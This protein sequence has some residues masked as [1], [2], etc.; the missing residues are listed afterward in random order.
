MTAGAAQTAAGG[1]NCPSGPIGL[2]EPCSDAH[3]TKAGPIGNIIFGSLL[4]G[5][6]EDTGTA[7]AVDGAGNVYGTTPAGGDM[8]C[9][10]NAKGCG[11]AFELSPAAN[12]VWNEIVLHTFKGAADGGEPRSGLTLDASGNLYGTTVFGGNLEGCEGSGCGVV[13][14]IIAQ[15]E[16]SRRRELR[17]IATR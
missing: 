4:G 10:L 1:G 12:G 6:G 2:P 8:N 16:S 9:S 11:V 13:F 7:I 5:A 17:K 3:I 14:E 15:R